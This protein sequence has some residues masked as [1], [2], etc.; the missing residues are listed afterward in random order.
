MST[1][2]TVVRNDPAAPPPAWWFL[3]T[4]VVEH[5]M[6][7]G[8]LPAVLEMT[9]P[10]GAAPP[11]HLHAGSDDSWYTVSGQ[12]VVSCGDDVFLAGAGDWVSLPRGVPH[13]FRVMGGPV[14]M[15]A[16]Q[17]DGE[18]LALVR[19]MGTPAPQRRLPGY[20]DGPPLADLSRAMAEHDVITVGPS[21]TEEEALAHLARLRG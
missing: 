6:A 16:V 10:A 15:L 7:S 20:E 21:M 12:M 9:L 2:S 11:R 1:A 14:V 13:S 8:G 17:A 3:G 4:L 5:T 19:A 18:F